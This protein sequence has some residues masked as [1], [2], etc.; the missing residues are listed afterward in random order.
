MVIKANLSA[1]EI[2]GLGRYNMLPTPNTKAAGIQPR[3]LCFWQMRE[4]ADE[5]MC[6][7]ADESMCECADAWMCGCVDVWM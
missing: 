2:F 1:L 6:E 5:S 3:L 4:C 7:C